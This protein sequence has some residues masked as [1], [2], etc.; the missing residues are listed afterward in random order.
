MTLTARV[1]QTWIEQA[2]SWRLAGIQFSTLD[3]ACARLRD[4]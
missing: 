4:A 1:S 2:D 3:D